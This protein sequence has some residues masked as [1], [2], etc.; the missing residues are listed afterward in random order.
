M[1]HDTTEVISRVVSSACASN[2][3]SSC[4]NLLSY[5]EA[6]IVNKGCHR[7]SAFKRG[8]STLLESIVRI[9]SVVDG[10]PAAIRNLNL[11][12]VEHADRLLN[13]VSRFVPVKFNHALRKF[14]YFNLS[15]LRT[16]N[17][18]FTPWKPDCGVVRVITFTGRVL[19]SSSESVVLAPDQIDGLQT[20]IKSISK[21]LTAN[22]I[23]SRPSVLSCIVT[24]VIN[25]LAVDVSPSV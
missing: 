17:F 20:F 6:I 25:L 23:H 2:S 24:H 3:S 8:S 1:N 19:R 7:D 10:S 21:D 14:G 11:D 15:Q 12:L 18:D 4:K 13:V 22:Y 5:R 9:A 16:N